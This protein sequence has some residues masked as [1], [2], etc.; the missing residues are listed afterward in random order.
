MFTCKV[1]TC[2]KNMNTNTNNKKKQMKPQYFI[3]PT[4]EKN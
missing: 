2:S 1:S 4:G 3:I